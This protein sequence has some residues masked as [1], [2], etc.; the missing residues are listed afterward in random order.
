MPS[1]AVDCATFARYVPPEAVAKS[2]TSLGLAAGRPHGVPLPVCGGC[3]DRDR[4]EGFEP[5]AADEIERQPRGLSE[6][7]PAASQPTLDASAEACGG[8]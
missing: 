8:P 5:P 6:P 3:R 4:S 1:P 7:A 2:C